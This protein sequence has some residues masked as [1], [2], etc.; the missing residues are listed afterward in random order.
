[1]IFGAFNTEEE[2]FGNEKACIVEVRQGF[3]T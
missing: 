2:M 1:M 3:L